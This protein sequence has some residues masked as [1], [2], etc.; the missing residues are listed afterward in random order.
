MDCIQIQG[1]PTSRRRMHIYSTPS[2]QTTPDMS[3][4]QCT[5]IPLG[6]PPY[7]TS[8]VSYL[9]QDVNPV[10]EM[11]KELCG[12]NGTQ[13]GRFPPTG[14]KGSDPGNQPQRLDQPHGCQRLDLRHQAV[15]KSTIHGAAHAPILFNTVSKLCWRSGETRAWLLCSEVTSD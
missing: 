11:Q 3:S 6:L 7:H 4:Y 5:W 9:N 10:G 12:Y 2:L 1:C 14:D 15:S 13:Q 8:K